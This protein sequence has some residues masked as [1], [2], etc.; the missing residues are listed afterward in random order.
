MTGR[1][2][3]ASDIKSP[4]DIKWSISMPINY[5]SNMVL[6]AASITLSRAV[7]LNR[8]L[9]TTIDQN[10]FINCRDN[11]QNEITSCEWIVVQGCELYD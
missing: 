9:F 8:F 10:H 1:T 7:V 3:F 6:Q 2:S 5:N 11:V 4:I